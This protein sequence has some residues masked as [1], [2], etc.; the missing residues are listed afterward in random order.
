[1]HASLQFKF[2]EA[3]C[4]KRG[5]RQACSRLPRSFSTCSR[6]RTVSLRATRRCLSTKADDSV[7]PTPVRTPSEPGS[8]NVP[9]RTRTQVLS[10]LKALYHS[11][12]KPLAITPLRLD[13]PSLLI[14]PRETTHVYLENASQA[15]KDTVTARGL[16]RAILEVLKGDGVYTV[17][18][19]GQAWWNLIN[20]LVHAKDL[21]RL[22]QLVR[23]PAFALWCQEGRVGSYGISAA[24]EMHYN[25]ART[26][27]EVHEQ[28]VDLLKL[29]DHLAISRKGRIQR[30]AGKLRSHL[31]N[32]RTTISTELDDVLRG[33]TTSDYIS[34]RAYSSASRLVEMVKGAR[35]T[36]PLDAVLPSVQRLLPRVTGTTPGPALLGMLIG[37]DVH[38][39]KD[40][41]R[42]AAAVNMVPNT[43]DWSRAVNNALHSAGPRAAFD[44]FEYVY[45]TPKPNVFVWHWVA[46]SLINHLLRHGPLQ[47]SNVAELELAIR[48]FKT[49]F[50]H[51]PYISTDQTGQIRFGVSALL[52]VLARNI[53]IP[54][55][56][57]HINLILSH[58]KRL[59]IPTDGINTETS[60][61]HAAILRA[62][63][64]ADAVDALARHPTIQN[65]NFKRMVGIIMQLR[66][67]DATV[68]AHEQFKRILDLWTAQARGT[69]PIGLFTAYT[70][71]VGAAV[72]ALRIDSAR[73]ARLLDSTSID[74]TPLQQHEAYA[75]RTVQLCE[76]L[77]IS[78]LSAPEHT[79]LFAALL[80]AYNGLSLAD[81]ERMR[82]L[83]IAHLDTSNAPA[84]TALLDS[85]GSMARLDEDWARVPEEVRRL[86]S[87][88]AAT[89]VHRLAKFSRGRR[90]AVAAAHEL[91][92]QD[93]PEDE[94]CRRAIAALLTLPLNP[95]DRAS[96]EARFPK[97]A[98][99][100][101]TVALADTSTSHRR[102]LGLPVANK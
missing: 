33:P 63:S 76:Q 74:S 10:Y 25:A 39:P 91:F 51:V 95:E 14:A 7:G 43:M 4:Y 97:T 54:D 87:G 73:G 42:I 11:S 44:V 101:R 81:A 62:E 46:Q 78:T 17:N 24:L 20:A 83:L 77:S 58:A 26:G 21:E 47:Y 64:H 66:F 92:S 88:L 55:R 60:A 85:A 89:Y 61:I 98:N 38:Q 99:D 5:M 52:A 65:N 94:G 23:S 75:L 29:A 27:Q 13:P 72:V 96:V 70:Q 86:D 40:V 100:S 19:V 68:L 69:P 49:Q 82:L 59:Q 84:L 80:T 36:L 45:A 41:E 30:I 90:R 34:S 50:E 102:R 48:V 28:I 79:P 22:D 16:S 9:P 93:D 2:R 12:Q 35:E 71:S 56:L 67:P 37:N 15:A 53:T 6:S 18:V 57:T 31:Y 3:T 8:S 1:M 32:I